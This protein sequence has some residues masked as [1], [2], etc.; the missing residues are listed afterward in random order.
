MTGDLDVQI[1]RCEEPGVSG[2]T[3]LC[4]DGDG[5]ILEQLQ[6]HPDG[7]GLRVS[8]IPLRRDDL[9]AL[10]AAISNILSETES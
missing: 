7:R 5:Y 6:D 8:H 4:R 2:S 9:V 3:L 1:V 10:Q